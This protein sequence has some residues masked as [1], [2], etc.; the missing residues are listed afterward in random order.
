Y[1]VVAHWDRLDW[2][3]HWKRFWTK[4]LYDRDLP[5]LEMGR[6]YWVNVTSDSFIEFIGRVPE[7]TSVMLY[8]SWNMIGY[9]SYADAT[10]EAVFQG[11]PL[12]EMEGF[13]ISAIP[14]GLR[15]LDFTENM[16][17]GEA[18]WVRVGEHFLWTVGN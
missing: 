3:D 7:N 4:K 2:Q 1:D 17:A 8:K 10:I 13:D 9:A 15:E 14:Y 12:L 6:G 16:N 5:S 11:L 18:Y